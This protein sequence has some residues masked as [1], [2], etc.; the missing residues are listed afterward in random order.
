[1]DFTDYNTPVKSYFDDRNYFYLTPT[2]SKISRVYLQ[3]NEAIMNDDYFKIR[4]TSYASFFSIEKSIVDFASQ[5]DKLIEISIM[6]GP[7]KNTYSRSVFTFMD[8]FGNVG[9]IYGL[10][11]SI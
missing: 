8:L 9:G 1:M 6:R 10:L 4:S 11:Q 3:Q 7:N 2:T 5:S